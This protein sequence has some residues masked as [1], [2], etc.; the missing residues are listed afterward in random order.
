[1]QDTYYRITDS[2]GLRDK[3]DLSR[4]LAQFLDFKDKKTEGKSGEITCSNQPL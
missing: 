3:W 2:W 1:M 4:Y